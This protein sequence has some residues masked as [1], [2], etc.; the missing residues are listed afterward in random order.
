MVGAARVPLAFGSRP[1]PL[2]RFPLTGGRPCPLNAGPSLVEA[3]PR[4]PSGD[5]TAPLRAG[6][7]TGKREPRDEVP[8]SLDEEGR[9]CALAQ[10]RRAP[11]AAVAKKTA[12]S[13]EK[14]NV[15][16]LPSLDS[17]Q[18]ISR[19]ECS[20][21]N[22]H[23]ARLGKSARQ[24]LLRKGFPS[25]RAGDW[26]AQPATIRSPRITAR[27]TEKDLKMGQC[28]TETLLRVYAEM[29]YLVAHVALAANELYDASQAAADEP[30]ADLLAE[31]ARGIAQI[32]ET[33]LNDARNAIGAD[34]EALKAVGELEA[35]YTPGGPA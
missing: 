5:A 30:G 29:V 4:H 24:P 19:R 7:P 22:A 1:R 13:S 6:S 17:E 34:P 16:P 15:G 27:S 31:L 28:S 20:S 35:Q 33:A 11:A 2:R 3:P 8:S 23:P 12:P 14:L 10:V 18:M 32:A 25:L 9:P 21:S 26:L